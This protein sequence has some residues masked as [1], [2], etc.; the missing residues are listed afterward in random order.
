MARSSV[1][2][3]RTS[4]TELAE[5]IGI[6]RAE[7]PHL[8]RVIAGKVA[9]PRLIAE[10]FGVVDREQMLERRQGRSAAGMLRIHL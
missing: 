4:C 6:V 7:N 1:G 8:G 9:K 5:Q 2:S 3:S 10:A